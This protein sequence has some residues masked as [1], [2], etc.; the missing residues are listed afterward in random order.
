MPTIDRKLNL[1]IPI[2]RDDGSTIRAYSQPVGTPVFQLYYR[3]IAKAYQQLYVDDMEVI[4]GPK[5]AALTLA[6]IAKATVRSVEPGKQVSWWEGPDGVEN[7]LL[8]E[9]RR[10]TS[11]LVPPTE[12]QPWQPI[13][14]DLAVQRGYLDADQVMEVESALVFFTLVSLMETR[15][16]RLKM[17][18]AT[19]GMCGWLLTS[20]TL[21]EFRDSLKTSTVAAPGGEVDQ[22]ALSDQ[23]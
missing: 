5:I 8:G 18:N 16:R 17:L 9:I 10:L 15:A 13:G 12:G 3:I 11:V 19:A 20:S 21:S 4:G 14:F 23:S 6:D 22:K 1:V 2:E 7:G